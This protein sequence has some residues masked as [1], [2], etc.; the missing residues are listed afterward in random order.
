MSDG[1]YFRMN[2]ASPGIY[3]QLRLTRYAISALLFAGVPSSGCQL[4]GFLQ[5]AWTMMT[6]SFEVISEGC[7][8]FLSHWSADKVLKGPH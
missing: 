4:Y 2:S 7:L 5:D 1:V 8:G 6:F 3:L